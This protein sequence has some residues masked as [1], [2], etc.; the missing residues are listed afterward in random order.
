MNEVNA[1]GTFMTTKFCLPYL[2]KSSNPHILIITPPPNM[3]PHWFGKSLPYSMSKYGMM[4]CVLGFSHE[5]IN[6]GIAVNGLWPLTTVASAAINNVLGGSEMMKRSRKATIMSD[7]A[8]E[9]ITCE[10]RKLTGNFFVDEDVMR[11]RGVTDFSGY[12]VTPDMKDEDLVPD[13]FLVPVRQ[14]K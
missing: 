5:F 9:I 12:R 13:G 6:D 7:A 8:W 2:K 14:N 4:M 11:A 3:E 10:S 1:R